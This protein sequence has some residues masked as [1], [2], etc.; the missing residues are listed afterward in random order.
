MIDNKYKKKC[1]ELNENKKKNNEDKKQIE[2]ELQ[3][4]K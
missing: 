2:K 3:K 4:Y 1:K